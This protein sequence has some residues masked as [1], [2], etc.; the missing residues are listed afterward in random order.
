M[1]FLCFGKWRLMSSVVQTVIEVVHN[2]A[3]SG[4]AHF[5]FQTCALHGAV[6]VFFS[7]GLLQ[8]LHQSGRFWHLLP[9]KCIL[10]MAPNLSDTKGRRGIFLHKVVTTYDFFAPPP[11]ILM[12]VPP[13]GLPCLLCTNPPRLYTIL[14]PGAK[15]D[16]NGD[17][18][19]EPGNPYP[20]LRV[21]L[22]KKGTHF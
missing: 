4:P 16:L 9:W 15:F 6:H 2:S 5:H 19:P 11:T 3:G 14:P 1:W 12:W 7:S 8:C 22:P 20:F 10:L 17:V 13:L 21:I 18:P